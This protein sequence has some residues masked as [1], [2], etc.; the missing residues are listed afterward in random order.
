MIT[1]LFLKCLE[2]SRGRRLISSG[3][4]PDAVWGPCKSYQ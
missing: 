3:K 4:H 1:V 2:P